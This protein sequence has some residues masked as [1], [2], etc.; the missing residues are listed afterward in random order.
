MLKTEKNHQEDSMEK[1]WDLKDQFLI[2]EMDSLDRSDYFCV[3]IICPDLDSFFLTLISKKSVKQHKNQV[4]NFYDRMM[5]ADS[6]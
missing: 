6:L 1:S 5:D 2:A 3:N 4:N